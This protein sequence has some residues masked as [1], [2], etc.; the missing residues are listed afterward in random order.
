MAVLPVV[1]QSAASLP[2]ARHPAERK[3]RR[4]AL[5]PSYMFLSSGQGVSSL[6]PAVWPICMRAL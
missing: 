5:G 3:G 4:R 2:V 1:R 6:L